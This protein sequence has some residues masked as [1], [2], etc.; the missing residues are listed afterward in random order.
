MNRSVHRAAHQVMV[1]GVD[2]PIG[3]AMIRE[4][5]RHGVLVHGI[6]RSSRSLGLYSRYITSRHV[7]QD[8]DEALLAQLRGIAEA[9]GCHWLMTVS[10]GDICWLQRM[11]ERLAPV[12]V[13]LVPEALP[14][15]RVLDKA[16]T[17]AAAQGLGI[18][19]PET[20]SWPDLA[21]MERAL[22]GLSFPL[23]LKWSHPARVQVKLDE[24]GVACEKSLYVHDAAQL[25][26]YLELVSPV[27]EL[28]LVQRFYPG[29][30]L[31]QMA[32]M[33]G[34]TA[35]LRF[36]HRRIAE[37]PP[38][39]GFSAVCESVGLDAH[40]DLFEHSL[41]LLRRL[42]FSGPAMVEY[43]FDPQTRQ[44]VLMEINGR[45]WGSLPLAY[46]AGA[47]FVWTAYAVGALGRTD[48]V[49]PAYRVGMRC[50]YIVPELKR[51]LRIT[52]S[53]GKIQNR[54]LTFSPAKEWLDFLAAYLDPRTRY[55]VFEVGDPL[56]FFSD[57]WFALTRRWGR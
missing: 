12:V 42:A 39:G 22:P 21:A 47:D 40:Q 24:I 37:W 38:E 30:G 8:G 44:A 4:L 51:L 31:G 48:T 2:S 14:M 32:Y 15:A 54:A 49:Q 56:P 25:R 26:A 1:L 9:T 19:T 17:I 6:G 20:W 41:E 10:E 3:L 29:Y 36:Q 27:G 16:T 50:R 33:A 11:R 18:A 43:R 57:L 52:F 23:V 35:L 46:H 53:P 55:F 5:G 28:P 45:F 7:R 34:G 13:A